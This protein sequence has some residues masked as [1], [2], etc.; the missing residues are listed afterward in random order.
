MGERI[1]TLNYFF[2]SILSLSFLKNIL[3]F[4]EKF[5]LCFEMCI[6]SGIT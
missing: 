4:E 3:C 1:I 6:S 5:V 2:R